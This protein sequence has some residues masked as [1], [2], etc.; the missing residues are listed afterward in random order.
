MKHPDVAVGIRG[1]ATDAAQQH[2]VRHGGEVGVY[3]EDG[4][5]R[6]CTR[7][8]VLRGGGSLEPRPAGT[9]HESDNC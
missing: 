1:R 2:A 3:L 9:G 6:A 4:Q 8:L 7:L 5:D